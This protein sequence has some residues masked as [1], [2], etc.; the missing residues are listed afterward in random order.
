MR[1]QTIVGWKRFGPGMIGTIL[2]ATAASGVLVSNLAAQQPRVRVNQI[3][4]QFEQGRPAFA[5]EHWQFLS[6]TLSPF[7][8]DDLETSL[9]SLRPE[10][11]SRPRMTPVVVPA[12]A[13]SSGTSR[14]TS[15]ASRTAETAPRTLRRDGVYVSCMGIK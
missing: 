5:N 3:I 10:G 4:E 8:L 1:N 13:A 11:S 15:A 2:A 6:L 9:A 12:C 7:L 14:P